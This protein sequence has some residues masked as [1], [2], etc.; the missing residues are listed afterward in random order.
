MCAR[1]GWKQ[2]ATVS[3]DMQVH[4]CHQR[5]RTFLP[6]ACTHALGPLPFATA[7]VLATPVWRVAVR[8]ARNRAMVPTLQMWDSPDTMAGI[9]T[10]IALST[11]L[12]PFC[13]RLK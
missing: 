7:A 13:L 2:S 9:S 6:R 3:L 12:A 4:L 5:A 8:V 10:R 1:G 11:V